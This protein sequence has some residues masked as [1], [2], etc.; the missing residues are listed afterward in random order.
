MTLARNK[1]IIILESIRITRKGLAFIACPHKGFTARRF[2]RYGVDE[3]SS[4]VLFQSSFLLQLLFGL[5]RGDHSLYEDLLI[6]EPERLQPLIWDRD[7]IR[8]DRK[9]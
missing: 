3:L 6:G 1:Y 7:V 5:S 8:P 2:H 9:S 4:F